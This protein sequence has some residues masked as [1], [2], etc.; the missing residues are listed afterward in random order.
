M[1][2]LD[3]LEFEVFPCCALLQFA[4]NDAAFTDTKDTFICEKRTTFGRKKKG[5]KGST[6][7]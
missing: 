7:V 5:K 6:L 2:T 3:W 1:K 4:G